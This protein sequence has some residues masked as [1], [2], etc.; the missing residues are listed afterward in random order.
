MKPGTKNSYKSLSNISVGNK[1]YKYYSLKIAEDNGLDGISKLPKS[2]K[3]L[4]ENLLR[5][6]DDLSVNKNQIESIKDW[7]KFKLTGII[8]TDYSSASSGLTNVNNGNYDNEIFKLYKIY[9]Q[10]LKFP[11]INKSNKKI[12]KLKDDIIKKININHKIEVIEGLHDVSAA[13]IGMGCI[14]QNKLLI[15]GGTFGIN[16]IIS[17]KPIIMRDSLCRMSFENNK[18]LNIAYTPSCSNCI[19]WILKIG[20]SNGQRRPKFRVNSIYGM[21]LAIEKGAGLASLPDYMVADKPHLVRVLPNLEGPSYQTYFVYSEAFKND[22]RL[23]VFR[24]FLFN[25]AKDWHY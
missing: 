4:L 9:D 18:W 2:L 13:M 8:S 15:I 10:R 23:E 5:Y 22:R 11:K 1:D 3:V 19:D 24:D 7:L 14:D 25:E 20:K 17:K 16:Q 21:S 6:E 12:G